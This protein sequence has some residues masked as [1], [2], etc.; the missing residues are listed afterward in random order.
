ML[1]VEVDIEIQYPISSHS[2]CSN[3]LPCALFEGM[4]PFRDR[5]DRRRQ[6][7]M[8]VTNWRCGGFSLKAD[9][10]AERES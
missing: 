10:M 1:V 5:T 4:I 8:P 3:F 6:L 2:N 9:L 7:L